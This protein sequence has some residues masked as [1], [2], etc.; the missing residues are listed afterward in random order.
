MTNRGEEE[1]IERKA[2]EMKNKLSEEFI[3]WK[4]QRLEKKEQERMREKE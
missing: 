1:R 3:K 4:R 2:Q